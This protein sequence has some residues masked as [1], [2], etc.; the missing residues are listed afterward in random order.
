MPCH[1][2]CVYLVQRVE[3]QVA[4][5]RAARVVG[6]GGEVLEP[7]DAPLRDH[8]HIVAHVPWGGSWARAREDAVA[9]GVASRGRG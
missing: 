1:E 6:D 4:L 2:S 3:Q 5:A 9:V 8:A 7:L